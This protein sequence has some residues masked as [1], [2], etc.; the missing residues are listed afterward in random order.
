MVASAIPIQIHSFS[1]E[2]I[3]AVY[4]P[5]LPTGPVRL[6]EFGWFGGMLEEFVKEEYCFR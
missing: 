5:N 1:M 6:K 4:A 3:A 2:K